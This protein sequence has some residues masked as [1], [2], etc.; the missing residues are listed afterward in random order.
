MNFGG[1][2]PLCSHLHIPESV[3]FQ[4][5]VGTPCVPTSEPPLDECRNGPNPH[6][7]TSFTRL[8]QVPSTAKRA[9][10]PASDH[11]CLGTARTS[12]PGSD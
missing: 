12:I 10:R 4:G 11:P 9:F 2:Q 5:R 1:S 6:Q 7:H 3:Q 8:T